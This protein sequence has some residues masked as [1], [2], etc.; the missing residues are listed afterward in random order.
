MILSKNNLSAITS[1]NVVK[2]MVNCFDLPVKV[3]QFGTGVLLRGLSDYIIDKANREQIFNGRIVVVK[4]TRQGDL[5]AF[6][7]QDN[8]YTLL[9]RGVENNHKKKENVICS[10]IAYVVSADGN[11]QKIIALAISPD[12]KVILSNTTEIGLQYVEESIHLSPPS[13]FPAK[14]LALLYKRYEHFNRNIEKKLIVIPT[15]LLPNNGE[16][17]KE[18]IVQLADFN[19]LENEFK[20]WLDETTFFCNSLVDRIVTGHPSS[21]EKIVIE[22]ELGYSDDL[23]IIA[24]AYYLWAIEG[25][26]AVKEILSFEKT[27]E[28][29]IVTADINNFR[30]LKLRLLNGTHTLSCALAILMKFKS[31][32]EAVD[33]K[34]FLLFMKSLMTEIGE[35]IPGKID[36][37]EAI[38]FSAKVLDR[39]RNPYIKHLWVNISQQYTIKMKTR[40]IPIIVESAKRFNKVSRAITIGFAAYL[41]FMRSQKIGAEY[42]GEYLGDDHSVVDEKA[43]YFFNIWQIDGWEKLNMKLKNDELWGYDLSL[44]T[45]FSAAVRHYVKGILKG[46]IHQLLLEKEEDSYENLS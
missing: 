22:G 3:I 6:R 43:P 35:S 31:V 13:S 23:M 45:G 19:E 26:D 42:K 29:I 25:N 21:E 37:K 11:W 17:L 10:A 4:S 39:F 34:S 30:E 33:D 8:L 27:D 36:A 44:L 12:L 18:I 46:N 9:I 2:P 38:D 24:E 7:E 15:E 5:K 40:V 16:I 28:N 1:N 32:G 41:V 20:L 14:L